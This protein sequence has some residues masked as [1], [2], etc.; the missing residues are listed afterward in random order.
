MPRHIPPPSPDATRRGF[1]EVFKYSRRALD[2]VWTTNRR[3]TI[4]LAILTLIGG[5]LPPAMAYVGAL[6]IDAVLAATMTF[7]PG[8]WYD[9]V[10]RHFCPDRHLSAIGKRY[11]WYLVIYA[12]GWSCLLG[13]LCLRL[14]E[15]EFRQ[16]M[17]DRISTRRGHDA[18]DS[19]SCRVRNHLAAGAH[20]GRGNEVPALPVAPSV[21]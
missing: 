3:L 4:T 14:R 19:R 9:L 17:Y 6:I 7:D 21:A 16:V 20:D 1:F 2:L 13:A 15:T 8:F 11:L 10:S 18:A 12:A 5:V